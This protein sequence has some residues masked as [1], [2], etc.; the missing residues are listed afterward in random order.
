[1]PDATARLTLSVGGI[2]I[3][4][5]ATRTGEGQISQQVALDAADAGAL[6]TRTSDTAGTL[7]MEEA[8]HGITTGAVIDIYWTDAAGDSQCAYGA[9]V[10]TVSGT[11][12][13]FTGAAGTVLPAQATEVTAAVV[14]EVN[15]IFDGDNVQIIACSNTKLGNVRFLDS[16]P[17]VLFASILLANEPWSWVIDSGTANPLTGNPVNKV[18]ISNGAELP[19]TFKLGILYDS[20]S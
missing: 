5:T 17:S 20:V 6:S 3:T 15:T 4:G 12:V 11:S 18:N 14:K 19:S 13:P 7:T 1:M 9:T 16:G 10:G 2:T 8:G